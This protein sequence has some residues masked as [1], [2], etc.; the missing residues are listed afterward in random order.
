[1]AMPVHVAPEGRHAVQVA[2]SAGVDQRAPLG[3]RDDERLLG[4]PVRHL[5]ERVPEMAVVPAGER[6]GVHLGAH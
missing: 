4:E 1:M 3:L 6:L 2:P 5:R